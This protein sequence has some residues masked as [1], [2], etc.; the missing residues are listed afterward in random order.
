MSRWLDRFYVHKGRPLKNCAKGVNLFKVEKVLPL[1][2][3]SAE[4]PCK[5]K[6]PTCY[7]RKV[8]Y[9]NWIIEPQL[10]RWLVSGYGKANRLICC[11]VMYTFV[12]ETPRLY[13]YRVGEYW[14]AD[15]WHIARPNCRV[16]VSLVLP[17]TSTVK[18]SN[19][20]YVTFYTVFC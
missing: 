9:T 8:S 4:T 3:I 7:L 16:F 20:D 11:S 1:I 17:F 5:C 13:T 19:I 14:L 10:S 2:T 12:F 15:T 18:T 6:S